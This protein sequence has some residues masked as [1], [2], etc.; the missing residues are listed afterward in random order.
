MRFPKV[1][2]KCSLHFPVLKPQ[3][4]PNKID[5]D[6]FVCQCLVARKQSKA[7]LLAV[8]IQIAQTVL[9]QMSTMQNVVLAFWAG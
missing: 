4:L 1:W 5:F 3:D 2:K 9:S 6:V 7:D 8:S